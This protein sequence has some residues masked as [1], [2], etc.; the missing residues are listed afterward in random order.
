MF[1]HHYLLPLIMVVAI[2]VALGFAFLPPLI[3]NSEKQEK[4]NRGL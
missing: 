2:L 1:H 3:E 4:R